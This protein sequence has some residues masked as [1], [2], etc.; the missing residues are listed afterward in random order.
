MARMTKEEK[1]AKMEAEAREMEAVSRATYPARLMVLLE[2]AYK[3]NFEVRPLA[4]RF[5]VQDRDEKLE[6]TVFLTLEYSLPNEEELEELE[7]QVNNKERERAEA[8]RK[9]QARQ[10]A[11]AKLSKEERELLGL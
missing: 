7:F 6:R 10:T 2:R 1:Q 9:Y 3:E 4:G 8:E 11:L 5:E